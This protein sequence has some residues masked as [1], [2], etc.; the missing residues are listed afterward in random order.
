MMNKGQ[1]AKRFAEN[2]QELKEAEKTS[3]SRVCNKLLQV[4]LLTSK[5][6]GDANDYRFILAYKELFDAFFSIVDF[7]LNIERHEQVV[8]IKNESV[9]NHLRLKKEESLIWLL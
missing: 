3:F 7:S 9:F 5:K 2:Y 6:I 1:A 4:N 8:Y